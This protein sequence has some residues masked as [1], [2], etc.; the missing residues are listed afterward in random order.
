MS[1]AK[2]LNDDSASFILQEAAAREHAEKADA[3]FVARMMRAISSGRETAEP[4]T[5][6]DHTAPLRAMR[7]TRMPVR[8]CCGSPADMCADIGKPGGPGWLVK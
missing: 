6:V 3:A 2:Y 8:S 5:F 7:F 4:G 1:L